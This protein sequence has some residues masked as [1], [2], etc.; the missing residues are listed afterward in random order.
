M[1][2]MDK[3]IVRKA[4][5]DDAYW[6]TYVNVY[7]RKTTYQWLIPDFLIENRIKNIDERANKMREIIKENWIHLVLED[8]ETQKIVWILSCCPSRNQEYPNSWEIMAIYVLKEY[9]KL[10]LG[11]K[12]FFAWIEE[13]IRLWYKDMIINVLK[14]NDAINFYKKYGGIVV[15]ERCDEVG[16]IKLHEDILYFK[17]IESIH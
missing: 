6:I 14:W 4:I 1:L 3:F 9:Q 5:P 11:K 2:S 16:K 8:T 15:W 13:L 12:L 17:N 10:W 7:T